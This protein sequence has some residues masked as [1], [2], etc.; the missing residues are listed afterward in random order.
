MI[1]Y[2]TAVVAISCLTMCV[3]STIVL[4][5]ARF[6]KTVKFR[7]ILTYA[8]IIL[9]A[10]SEWAGVFLNGAPE[11]TAG[12]HRL[13]KC[14]DYTVTPIA[15]VLFA[16]QI[17]DE[18]RRKKLIWIV[19]VLCGNAIFEILSIFTEWTFYLDRENYYH[20]GKLYFIYV[21]IYCLAIVCVLISFRTYSKKFKRK[22]KI[23]LYAIILL[24]CLGIALQEIG[25]GNIRTS[26]LSL[27]FG[28]VLLYIHYN[29]FIQQS[30][31]DNLSRQKALIETDALTGMLSRYSYIEALNSYNEAA[32]LPRNLTVFTIDINGLK[33]VNDTLGHHA[34]D[35]LICG[36]A[37]CI[38]KVFGKYGKCFRTGGDEFIAILNI[39]KSQAG[40]IQEAL[41]AAAEKWKGEAA[42]SLSLS[43]GYAAAEDHPDLSLERLVIIADEM[44]YANKEAYY[45]RTGL[46]RYAL[47][48]NVTEAVNRI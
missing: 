3:L 18:K 29:E 12:I 35:E 16:L 44:M 37:K 40:I 4:E 1:E 45:R 28:S 14:L 9:S 15:G 2:Y 30:D 36:A 48:A 33:I 39:D 5:N 22:Y 26:C 11:W 38:S 31:N 17:S 23:S 34:G 24:V 7:F 19:F 47:S 25:N 27:A 6:D 10:L 13:V 42:N 41:D 32:E 8:F 21:I 20:H 43:S 46:N